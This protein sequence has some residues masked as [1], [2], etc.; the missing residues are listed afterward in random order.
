MSKQTR[1]TLYTDEASV[2]RD[3]RALAAKLQALNEGIEMAAQLLGGNIEP[4][5]ARG[6][7]ESPRA[8]LTSAA[9]ANVKIQGIPNPSPAKVL[10]LMG[11]NLEPC[12]AKLMESD[13]ISRYVVWGKGAFEFKPTFEQELKDHH[14]AFATTEEEIKVYHTAKALLDAWLKLKEVTGLDLPY[15][16]LAHA[17][18]GVLNGNALEN[19]HVNLW[20]IQ[21][22]LQDQMR[23]ERLRKEHAELKA[24]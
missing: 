17:S 20:Y 7:M 19:S 22:R 23:A 10:D 2:R 6:L 13:G 15:Q 12:I 1:I 11:L 9:T 8:T 21:Q 16:S 3:L 14:S 4:H 18:G 24:G 5:I